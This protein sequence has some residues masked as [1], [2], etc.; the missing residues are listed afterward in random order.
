M[1]SVAAGFWLGICYLWNYFNSFIVSLDNSR[2]G[3]TSQ[4]DT[5][6]SEFVASVKTTD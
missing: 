1:T 2:L 6:K 5:I 3:D 4:K